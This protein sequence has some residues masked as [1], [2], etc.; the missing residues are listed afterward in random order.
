MGVRPPALPAGRSLGEGWSKR[1][2]SK[3]WPWDCEGSAMETDRK[4]KRFED[5]I[6]W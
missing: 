5:L 6:V 1:S 2:A 4:I 3:G